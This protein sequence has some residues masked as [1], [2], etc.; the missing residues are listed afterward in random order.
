MIFLKKTFY[1][2]EKYFKK[3]KTLHFSQFRPSTKRL[4]VHV[5]SY[6][7]HP[8]LL[9]VPIELQV[10]GLQPSGFSSDKSQNPFLQRSQL[11]FLKQ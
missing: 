7:L 6:L 8:S 3:F 4:H 11:K 5:P 10:Q 2:Y 1:L 9:I